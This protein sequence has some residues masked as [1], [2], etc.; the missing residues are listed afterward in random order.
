MAL[1]QP[2]PRGWSSTFY[3]FGGFGVLGGA[4]T[5]VFAEGGGG[6]GGGYSQGPETPEAHSK[7]V[8]Y[9]FGKSAG[10]SVL[11]RQQG[12]KFKVL[13]LGSSVII[14]IQS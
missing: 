6:G 10:L 2:P 12:S 9:F 3:F 14:T 1:R 5:L 11:F 7:G 8:L 4:L 13:V